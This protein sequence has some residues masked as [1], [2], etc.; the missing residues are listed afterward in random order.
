MTLQEDEQYEFEHF[1]I[2]RERL[3]MWRKQA[4]HF[5]RFLSDPKESG[6]KSCDRKCCEGERDEDGYYKNEICHLC[7]NILTEQ[8]CRER[9]KRDSRKR[10]A[11]MN[12]DAIEMK[13]NPAKK[14]KHD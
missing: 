4:V 8:L 3:R 7:R 14:K 11:E 2:D 1:F 12:R 5:L 6:I 9:I 13:T 10:R